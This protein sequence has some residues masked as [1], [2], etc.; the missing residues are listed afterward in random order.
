MKVLFLDFDGV[1]GPGMFDPGM[2]AGGP[3][4]GPN[5]KTERE[6]HIRSQDQIR[7]VIDVT[8]CKVVLSTAWRESWGTYEGDE[9]ELADLLVYAGVIPSHDT[10]IG[11]TPVLDNAMSRGTEI[12][13]WLEEHRGRVDCFAI[14]DDHSYASQVDRDV[15]SG[16]SSRLLWRSFEVCPALA[17]RFVKTDPELGCTRMNADRLIELL[18]AE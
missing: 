7:R 11:E 1:L 5:W 3:E 16:Q 10:V 6:P 12:R 13:A 18:G 8:G 15:Q 2:R 4:Y 14:V 9:G 17:A